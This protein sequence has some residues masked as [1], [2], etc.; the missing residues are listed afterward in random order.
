MKP[1]T[2]FRSNGSQDYKPCR[3]SPLSD[4]EVDLFSNTERKRKRSRD[5]A[6][7]SQDCVPQRKFE[8]IQKRQHF[9]Q[10]DASENSSDDEDY[11]Q[12]TSVPPELLNRLKSFPLFKNAPKSFLTALGRSLQPIQYNPQEYI[13]KAG[14]QA[15]SMYWILRGTVGV[16]STDGE[17]LYAELAA[18]S[19]F[20]E[21][22]ILFNRP[23]TATVVA[24]TKV[25]LGV[26]TK[27]ALSGVLSDY[28]TIERLIR[29]EGQER[30]SMQQKR[31]RVPNVPTNLM[32]QRWEPPSILSRY[33]A[34]SLTA[35]AND[36]VPGPSLPPTTE[37]AMPLFSNTN[38]F[39][40]NSAYIGHVAS[41]PLGNIDNSISVREFLSSLPLF[42]SL[43]NEVFHDLALKV[44]IKD[45]KTMEYIFRKG[46]SGRDIYFVVHGEVEV[47]DPE[48][49]NCIFARLGSG[50]YF[51]EMAFLSSL[52]DNHDKLLAE[53]RSADIR[54]VSDSEVLIVKGNV[55]EYLC[56]RYPAVSEDM[57]ITAGERLKSNDSFG[58]LIQSTNITPQDR[59]VSS[60]L[61]SD[62][63]QRPTFKNIAW[64]GQNSDLDSEYSMSSPA[65]TPGISTESV[66]TFDPVDNFAKPVLPPIDSVKRPV[67]KP[68]IQLNEPAPNPGVG[69]L[70]S[71]RST[72]RSQFTYTPHDHRL[73]L[74]SINNGRRR[75]SVL[76]SGPLPDSIFLKIFALLDLPHLMRLSVV[77]K[78][79]KQLLY[80]GPDLM[81]TLDLTPWK[82][83]LDDSSLIQITNF[84]GPRPN[85]I[86]ITGCFHITD[87]GFTY[88]INEIGIRGCIKKLYMG[89]HWNISAMA[90]MDLS[91]VAREID[92]IDFSNCPK[93]RDDVIERLISPRDSKYGCPNL[94]EMDLSYCKYLTDK[95]MLQIANNTGGKITSL[96]LTR[97]TTITDNGFVFWTS[98]QF[99]FMKKLVL[100]DCTFLSDLA[101]SRVVLACPNLEVLDLTFCCVLTDN[102]L[103]LIYLYCKMLK[104]LNL[105]FCGSAVSDNSLASISKL[106]YL[107]DLQ[108]TGCIRVSRQGVDQLLSNLPN[109]KYLELSQ[110]PRINTYQGNPVEPFEKKPGTRSA[111]LKVSPHSRI[112][113]VVL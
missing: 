65:Y 95:T 90:I 16:T 12:I 108:I 74:Q 41:A 23:R 54:A 35:L 46:D 94:Q 29:D 91:I 100:K 63:D 69:S 67:E 59:M 42:Q 82:R 113:Q 45:F 30:L 61:I 52:S 75:S 10:E 93:V 78:K 106:A 88:M 20:G 70:Y 49:S 98:N 26:L 86:N 47:L 66:T 8:H 76:S 110:C 58:D 33:S 83:D 38:P 96:N 111:F 77:C 84:V 24:R 32:F 25:L 43:P 40:T 31:K 18:G 81:K 103:A 97:C 101:I 102:A 87:A 68:S 64:T 44:E 99:P 36:Q 112:V 15:K 85:I 39:D 104:S 14:E 37:T 71:F 89:D 55:L 2:P 53:T 11:T 22:G 28:P 17:A 56:N 48:I 6:L 51:G 62:H 50:K 7:A 1:T 13:V 105:S 80:L 34:D 107:E 27:D 60:M 72:H 5:L 4:D 79:W 92:T 3:R 109:L 19:F 57:K 21:I 73:R 9:E